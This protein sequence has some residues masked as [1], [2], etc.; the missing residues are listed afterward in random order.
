MD[1]V[2]IFAEE[3]DEI[4]FIPSSIFIGTL[5]SYASE[6]LIFSIVPKTIGNFNLSF[7]VDFKNGDNQ[8]NSTVIVPIEVVSNHDVAPVIYSFPETIEKGSLADIR[9]EVYNAKT[10]E[11][12]GVIVKPI[13]D[14]KMSPSEYFIGSMDPDDVFSASFDLDTSNLNIGENYTVDFKV[15]FKQGNNYYETDSVSSTFVLTEPTIEQGSNFG[16]FL[17]LFIVMIIIIYFLIR[18]LKKRRIFK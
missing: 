11:I 2:Q 14:I 7:R 5:D 18:F 9:L 13:T 17:L 10:E 8:H 6:D 4:D 3:L 16:L 12:T 15:S 1:A